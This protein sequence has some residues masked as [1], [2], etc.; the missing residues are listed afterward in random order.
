MDSN[1]KTKCRPADIYIPN[2]F[3]GQQTALDFGVTSGLRSDLL[4]FSSENNR[5][6]TEE[7]SEFKK[8]NLDTE[9]NCKNMD[10]KFIP[11]VMEGSAG[12]WG[13]EAELVWKLIIISTASLTKEPISL[14]S[15]HIYQSLSMVLHKADARALLKRTPLFSSYNPVFE[16]AAGIFTEVDGV[17]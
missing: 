16:G 15:N 6:A 3:A 10:I 13:V 9:Q 5:F 8:N 11:M 2:F 17:D 7:Y 12:S 1:T 14:V 4:Q